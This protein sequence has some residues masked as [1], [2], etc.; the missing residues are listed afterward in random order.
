MEVD[1]TPGMGD[2][3]VGGWL[4]VA[5]YF[6]AGIVCARAAARVER[7]AP[8]AEGMSPNDR[9][10]W[11]GACCF[12]MLLGLNKQLDL[13]SLLTEFG[14]AAAKSQ[15]W[16]EERQRYRTAFV[17]VM[18]FAGALVLSSLAWH[19]RRSSP[20]VKLALAGLAVTFAFVVVRAASFHHLD[21]W[22][23][24]PVLGTTWNHVFELAGIVIV[25]TAAMRYDRRDAEAGE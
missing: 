14:R 23:G 13:Q 2:P 22:F 11:V 15:N 24:A 4:S 21:S 12:F 6:G 20:A 1:W 5:A 10:F 8:S 25:A 7:S 9:Y 19:M 16:Y 3:T 17:G 18:T